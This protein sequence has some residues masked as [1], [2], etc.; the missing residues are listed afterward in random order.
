M[1]LEKLDVVFSRL[2]LCYSDDVTECI[3]SDEKVIDLKNDI[4]MDNPLILHVKRKYCI[5]Y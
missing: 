2:S 3:R 5:M 4:S 1:D